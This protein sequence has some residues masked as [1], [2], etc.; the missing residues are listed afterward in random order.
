VASVASRPA[1]SEFRPPLADPPPAP[2]FQG[3]EKH[4]FE[5]LCD[6]RAGRLAAAKP[7]CTESKDLDMVGARVISKS[8]DLSP[9]WHGS[10]YAGSWTE[11]WTF[12]ACGRRAEVPVTFTADGQGGANWNVR[13]NEA[14]LLD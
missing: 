1:D 14:K 6:R 2:P 12:S 10:R 5:S 8:A 7:D 13:A 11:G 4:S 3:G 9:D